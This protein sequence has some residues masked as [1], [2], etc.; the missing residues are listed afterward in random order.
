ML[1]LTFVN[2]GHLM[3][4]MHVKGFN[5]GIARELFE[6]ELVESGCPIGNDFSVEH[7]PIV[8]D[9]FVVM[10]APFD[11]DGGEHHMGGEHDY[12]FAERDPSVKIIVHLNCALIQSQQ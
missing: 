8:N 6:G 3:D 12:V 1:D 9:V 11:L 4:H 2:H 5:L 10:G 7:S